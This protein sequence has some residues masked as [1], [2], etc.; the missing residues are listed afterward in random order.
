MTLKEYAY[1]AI[2]IVIDLAAEQGIKYRRGDFRIE[3][4]D[5]AKGFGLNNVY[6]IGGINE[7]SG[8]SVNLWY[9]FCKNRKETESRKKRLLQL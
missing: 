1:A 3:G 7:P 5:K 8:V 9:D 4:I 2:D 6:F